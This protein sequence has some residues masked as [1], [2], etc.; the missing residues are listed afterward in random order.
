MEPQIINI[1]PGFPELWLFKSRRTD[2][3]TLENVFFYSYILLWINFLE[4]ETTVAVIFMIGWKSVEVFSL[5]R[6]RPPQRE[7]EGA[8]WLVWQSD[9]PP[10]LSPLSPTNSPSSTRPACRRDPRTRRSSLWRW[11]SAT[12]RWRCDLVTWSETTPARLRA[13]NQGPRS[14]F[15]SVALGGSTRGRRSS[16]SYIIRALLTLGFHLFKWV[17]FHGRASLLPPLPLREV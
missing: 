14:K 12:P 2:L 3:L 10:L 6:R 9:D 17:N 4:I 11:T 7:K 15:C 16:R 8:A 5:Y 1:P 13:A